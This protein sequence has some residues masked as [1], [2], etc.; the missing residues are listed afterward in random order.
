MGIIRYL[1]KFI[2]NP[3]TRFGYLSALGFYNWLSDE[4]YVRKEWKIIRGTKLNLDFP[5]TFN[6]KLQ[7][8]K[9]NDHKPEYTMMVDKYAAKKYVA[10]RIGEEHIIPTLGVYNRFEEID[11]N[12]LPNKFV[13][14]CTHDSGAVVICRDKEKLNKKEIKA[15]LT[16]HLKRKYYYCHREWP[17][18]NV[19]PRIIAEE[20]MQDS[21][22]T[23]LTDYKFYCFNGIPQ[24]LYVSTGLDNHKTAKVSFVNTDWKLMN[25]RRTD[26]KPLDTLPQ[27]PNCFLEMLDIAKKLSEDIPFL[28]V[29]LYE[30]NGIVYFG[31]LTFTPC[32]GMMPF[33]PPSAD[34]EIGKM[35][36]I[37]HLIKQ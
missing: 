6:E 21:T 3:K 1:E 17:Y 20:Y 9:V 4:D 31:E 26:Y 30:I 8:L 32:A 37:S 5:Q 34:F 29:D 16:K 27:K 28:R 12:S 14:K 36:D 13:L 2:R 19:P 15:K 33:D 11:F 18:K 35:L 24:Y 10:E 23:A 25:F 7:W 22:I